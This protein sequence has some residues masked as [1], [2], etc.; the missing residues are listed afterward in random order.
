MRGISLSGTDILMFRLG[1]SG[2]IATSGYRGVS[3]NDSGNTYS[4][5]GYGEGFLVDTGNSPDA[6]HSRHGE[7]IFTHMGNNIFIGAGNS[8]RGADGQNYNNVSSGKVELA[9]ACTTLRLMASGSNSFDA[10][11][12]TVL[13][14]A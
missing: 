3:S 9:G 13:T 12:I 6:S 10:G 8:C 4:Y 11:E 14:E 7:F 5:S 2:G 1:T